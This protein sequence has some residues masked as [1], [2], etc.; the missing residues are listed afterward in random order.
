V[1]SETVTV[2]LDGVDGR[3]YADALAAALNRY[4]EDSADP[5]WMQEWRVY[6]DG[7]GLPLAAGHPPDDPRVLMAEGVCAGAP[8]GLLDLDGAR[9]A[10]SAGAGRLWDHWQDF[11]AAYPKARSLE[12]LYTE[13]AADPV[14]YDSSRAVADYAA[15]PV[16]MAAPF[17]AD[18]RPPTTAPPSLEF[19]PVGWFGLTRGEYIQRRAARV[20]PTAGL[21]TREGEWLDP[22]QV[23]HGASPAEA[24]IND[25]RDRLAYFARADAYLRGLPADCFVVRVR[26]RL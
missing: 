21:L 6:G 11:A 18:G 9:A 26:V 13:S 10:A 8:R 22:D 4:G 17:L 24:M 5:R 2:C 23:L 7:D 14:R 1:S 19:D 15:Q 12:D 3:D 25:F 20:L 16:V